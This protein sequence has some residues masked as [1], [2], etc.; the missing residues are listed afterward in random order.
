M[1]AADAAGRAR[2][3][4]ADAGRSAVHGGRRLPGG[5]LLAESS[6]RHEL[7]AYI[8]PFRGLLLGLFFLSVGMSVDLGVVR[9]NWLSLVFAAVVLTAIKT[10]V[11]YG[12][13][14]RFG[15][16]HPTAVRAALLLRRAG[17]SASCSTRPPPPPA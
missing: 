14:P 15:H 8:E 2:G 13:G 12:V 9:D 4:G 6:Y 17:N 16:D 10:T 1:T 3:G 5:R 7:E 11:M